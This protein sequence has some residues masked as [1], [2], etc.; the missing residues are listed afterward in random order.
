[1]VDGRK[2]PGLGSPHVPDAMSVFT[3]DLSNNQVIDRFK[4]GFQIGQVVEGAEIVGGASP[5]SIA[6]GKPLCVRVQRH[7]RHYFGDRLEVA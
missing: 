5:N 7:R 3:I 2:I 4:T 6:V 1:M